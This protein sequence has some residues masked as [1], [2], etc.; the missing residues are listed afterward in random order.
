MTTAFRSLRWPLAALA[1]IAALL[2]PA[3]WNGFPIV[4]Y[5]TGGYLDAAVSG[6]LANGRSTLY[7][8][9][10]RLGI[11]TNFWF[12][13]I[14]QAGAAAWLIAVTLR[15]HGLGGRPHLAASVTLA[16][17]ALTSLPWYAAQL[18][19]DV[20]LPAGAVALYL[21]AFR[22]GAFRPWEKW[23]LGFIVAFAIAGHM[24][25]LAVMIGLLAALLLWFLLAR[26]WIWPRPA[27]RNPTLAVLAG[28]LLIL[29]ANLAIAGRF[30]FTPGG[31]NFLFGRLVQT[32][33]AKR[34]LAEHCPDRKLRACS[35]RG[36]IPNKGDDWLWDEKSPLWRIG[37]WEK[38]AGEARHIVLH[39]L[40]AYPGLH[41]R[42]AA[43]GA[44]SQFFML[45]TGDDITGWAWHTHGI[46]KKFAPK[47]YPAFLA[48]PQQRTGFDFAG[49]NA[50]HVPVAL[51]SIL[52]LPVI[53]LLSRG[54]RVRRSAAALS[55]FVLITLAGNAAVCG[56]LSNPHDRYQSR[57]VWLAPLALAVALAGMRRPVLAAQSPLFRRSGAQTSAA[58][59]EA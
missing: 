48:A 6:I 18:M 36:Q 7:G 1:M 33:I 28:V 57:L 42:A 52:G 56:V 17:A 15:A 43:S 44:V 55:L 13:I 31:E 24:A 4:F 5:D 22:A 34:Y 47:A 21:L 29:T 41:L 16:L 35:F 40:S 2:W 51:A 53:V 20:W 54:R 37:G 27:L 49:M 50:L 23:L 10:L 58:A 19:P 59:Q 12:N 32:G 8:M 39:S 45:K 38:F 26:R 46:L 11:P 30:T 25:T 14:V 3:L 9:F